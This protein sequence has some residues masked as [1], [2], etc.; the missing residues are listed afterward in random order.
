[1][2]V[3]KAA[4]QLIDLLISSLD[5]EIML[6]SAVI[7]GRATPATTISIVVPKKE[8]IAEMDLKPGTCIKY[9]FR[10]K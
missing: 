2:N 6:E 10:N 8:D 7:S 3:E 5:V 9:Q 1:M 4:H